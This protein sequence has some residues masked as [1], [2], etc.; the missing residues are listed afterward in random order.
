MNPGTLWSEVDVLLKHALLT[1]D[2]CHRRMRNRSVGIE[3]DYQGIAFADQAGDAGEIGPGN[4]PISR[5][6]IQYSE[7]FMTWRGSR[8]A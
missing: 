6:G 8:N 7:N 3:S 5:T 2:D 4:P 1:I